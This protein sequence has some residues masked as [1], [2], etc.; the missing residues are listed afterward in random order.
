M[1]LVLF[2]GLHVSDC[3]HGIG[4]LCRAGVV[5]EARGHG[6][7]KKLIMARTVFARNLGLRRV[8]TYTHTTNLPSMNNLM[9]SGFRLYEPPK[10]WAEDGFLYWELPL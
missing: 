1:D 9:A 8:T 2:A 7:Q 6:L 3:D 5:E 10:G 4:I